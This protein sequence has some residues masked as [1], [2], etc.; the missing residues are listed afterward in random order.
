MGSYYC[1][2]DRPFLSA[3]GK[4][5]HIHNRFNISNWTQYTLLNI[6]KSAITM[7]NE[8]FPSNPRTTFST[9]ASFRSHSQPLRTTF[10]RNTSMDSQSH[11]T[12]NAMMKFLDNED[13]LML[14][15]D[16]RCDRP[17]WRRYFERKQIKR[18]EGS[19]VL[20]AS[21][22]NSAKA[23]PLN[24]GIQFVLCSSMISRNHAFFLFQ[25]L[26][27]YISDTKWNSLFLKLIANHFYPA[28]LQHLP[29]RLLMYMHNVDKSHN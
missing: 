3:Q 13:D 19:T 9:D 7:Y 6:N 26:D 27:K 23:I 22:S 1:P 5:I 21:L 20:V 12:L 2:Y 24:L 4:K 29:H 18:D 28:R 17:R 11:W 25:H 14:A 8:E 16:T 15:L 10:P